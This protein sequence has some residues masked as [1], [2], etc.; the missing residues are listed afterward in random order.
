[1]TAFVVGRNCDVNKFR[2]RIGVT[3]SD[4]GNVDVRCFFDGLGVGAGIGDD[5]EPRFLEGSGNV[6]GEI[7]GSEPS[8]NGDCTRMSRK[9]ENRALT[10]RASRD[11]GDIGR[12][13]HGRDDASCQ[14]DFFPFLKRKIS[15]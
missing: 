6:V 10:V 7:P 3:E 9:L 11:D 8:G 2:R 4:D 5:D 13:V 15:I 14:N 1:M 12:V